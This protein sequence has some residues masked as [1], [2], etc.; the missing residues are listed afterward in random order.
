MFVNTRKQKTLAGGIGEAFSWAV[1]LTL[2]ALPGSDTGQP[3][4]PGSCHTTRKALSARIWL[5]P[6]PASQ[7]PLSPSDSAAFGDDFTEETLL[8]SPP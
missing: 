7:P 2:P 1:P 5:H 3:N 4:P 6:P 8:L